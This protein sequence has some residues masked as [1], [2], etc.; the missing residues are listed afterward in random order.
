MNQALAAHSEAISYIH[1]SG[2]VHRDLKSLAIDSNALVVRTSDISSFGKCLERGLGLRTSSTTLRIA[3][4][5]GLKRMGARLTQEVDRLRLQQ[6]LL[7]EAPQAGVPWPL[8][9]RKHMKEA[10]G[11]VSYVAP[12]ALS[13]L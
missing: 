5:C 7:H 6:V 1:C 10:L 2:V 12:E 11:T 8:Q 3:T 4:S 9:P 13:G